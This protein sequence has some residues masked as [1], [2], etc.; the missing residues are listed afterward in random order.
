M[1]NQCTASRQWRRCSPRAVLRLSSA[2]FLAT[3]LWAGS[4][5]AKDP[6]RT[7]DARPI[8]DRTEAAFRA[9][10][11][12][13]N[14]VEAAKQLEQVEPNEPLAHALRASLTF[15][16]LEGLKDSQTAS[17]LLEEFRGQAAQTREAAQRMVSSDP[18]RGNLYL[19]VGHFLEAAYVFTKEGT[20]KGTPQVLGQLQQVL[21]YMEA[22]EKQ[23]PNDPELSLIKGYMD[24]FI[25][26]N[27]PFSDP[28]KGLDRLNRYASPRYLAEQGVALGYRDLKE[29]DKAMAA[30]DRAMQ[31]A[32][33]NPELQY[34]KAQILV[35]QGRYKEGVNYFQKALQKQNQLPAGKVRQITRELNRAQTKANG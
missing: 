30:V 24:L 31:A 5:V 14:Y 26:L 28:N 6:F 11:Q 13:G 4:A 9:L 21:G 15:S 35:Q 7:T 10:F 33:E 1:A 22:A 18:L 12:N 20:V 23:N 25:G 34:L 2:V 27:L 3:S 8:S 16:K 17:A 29:S 19:A 32:P